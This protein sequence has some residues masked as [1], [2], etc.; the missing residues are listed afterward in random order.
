M[1]ETSTLP[2]I[3]M[4]D[5]EP[6]ILEGY[7]RALHGRFTVVTVGSGTDGLDTVRRAVNQGTPYPVIV[8]DMMMPTMNGAE[9]LGKARDIDPDA[10]QLLLSGQADL[11]STIS[12]VNNGKLFRFLTKPCPAPD[13]EL[14]L[15]AALEQH[16]LVGAE[17]ELLESTLT[18]AIDVLTDLLS[19]ASPEAFTRTERVRTVVNGAAEILGVEDWQLPLA[20][21]LSQIGCVAVPGDVLH[22]ARTGGEL[23]DDEHDVYMAH[24]QTARRLLER[25]PRLEKVARWVGDQPVRPP[26]LVTVPDDWHAMAGDTKPELAETLLRAGLALLATLDATGHMG[27]AL[28]QL[29][30]SGHYPQMVLDALDEAAGALAAQGVRRELTVD[31]VRPGMLLEQDVETV[32]GMIL[33][34]KGERVTEAVAMRLEN[35]ARTVGI[36]EPVIVLDGV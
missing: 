11:E 35:F 8:S 19:M 16:R 18:G 5:D 22:R 21:M 20:T 10:I 36:Q 12:A 31:H 4:V 33:V 29:T 15:N 7:R 32:T 2:A 3:L 28:L 23:T 1:T 30:K 9:F 25:I 6:N 24:P 17:R 26:G 27:R 14:A 13:L 34:R